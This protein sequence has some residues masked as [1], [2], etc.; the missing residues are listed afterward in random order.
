MKSDTAINTA[1]WAGGILTIL[2]LIGIVA[3]AFP[4]SGDHVI[5][6]TGAIIFGSGVIAKAISANRPGA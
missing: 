2:G 6:I 4:P 1:L 5:T 3:G